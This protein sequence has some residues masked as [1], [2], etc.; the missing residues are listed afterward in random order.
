[1]L[2]DEQIKFVSVTDSYLLSFIKDAK[3]RIVIVKPAYKL[4]EVEAILDIIKN[5]NVKCK[6]YLEAG[7]QSIRNGLGEAESLNLIQKNFDIL[8]VQLMDKIR[9]AIIIIDNKSVIYTPNISL[10]EENC[11]E[12]IIPNGLLGNSA[13]TEQIDIELFNNEKQLLINGEKLFL[14]LN[15]E[16]AK[17]R[18][19][20]IEQNICKTIN[21]LSV[22]PPIGLTRLRKVNFYRNNY[23]LVKIQSIGIRIKNKKISLRPFTLML[24]NRDE[25]EVRSW[26]IFSA[27]DLKKL[28]DT[29]LFYSELRKIIENYLLDAG[30]F[31]YI[32]NIYKKQKFDKEINRLKAEFIEFIKGENKENKN[33]RF[34]KLIK[35]TNSKTEDNLQSILDNSRELLTQYLLKVSK[36]DRKLE[37]EIY[38]K[39]RLLVLERNE[40]GLSEEEVR[41]VFIKRYITTTLKFPTSKDIIDRIDVKVDYF[42]ISDE[43]IND[44]ND[45]KKVINKHNTYNVKQLR[46]MENSN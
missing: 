25:R 46:L 22:N 23:K 17:D 33:N 24:D 29:K 21:N 13:I 37:N 4:G 7:E 10:F 31:G 18:Y 39:D 34:Y 42:D 6:V 43:L 15:S 1:M 20:N 14:S 12:E 26:N 27:D 2:G 5:K 9:I 8:N 38:K 36:D 28:G 40:K 32:L 41:K 11:I 3:E 44:N 16:L 45:F 35:F 19:I 30:R